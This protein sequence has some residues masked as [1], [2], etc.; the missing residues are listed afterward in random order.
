M[1]HLRFAL[2]SLAQ[3]LVAGNTLKKQ[4]KHG[5]NFYLVDGIFFLVDVFIC[6]C[7]PRGRPLDPQET[8]VSSPI[9]NYV[10]YVRF[11]DF[12]VE[13]PYEWCYLV[14][15]RSAVGCKYKTVG[16]I[17]Q[18][19]LVLGFF[20]IPLVWLE[21]GWLAFHEC[22]TFSNHRISVFCVGF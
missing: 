21:S 13:L 7:P 19:G 3:E 5:K 14:L 18:S 4:I 12:C 8:L 15:R 10:K 11:V 6:L 2:N 16:E 1:R 22:S 9:F 20:L 17:S